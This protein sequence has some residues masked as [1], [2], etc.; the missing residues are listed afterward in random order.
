MRFLLQSIVLTPLLLCSVLFAAPDTTKY[1]HAKILGKLL[2]TDL[3]LSCDE[4]PVSQVLHQFQDDLNIDMFVFWKS[5]D[6]DGIDKSTPI[7]LKLTN[8][9]AIVVLERIIEKL[10]N[11]APTAWQ[12]RDSMLEIGFKER[13]TEGSA[14]E[15]RTYDV[16]NLMF[17]IRDFDNAPTMGTT[18]G[19]GVNF[20]DPTDDPNRLTKNEEAE[21][22]INTI[23]D[24]IESEQ[25]KVHGG[26]CTIRFYK[27]SLLVKA[28]DFVHRQLGGY[29]F[30]PL[31][32]KNMKTRTIKFSGG[33]ASVRLPRVPN[34]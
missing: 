10:N 31:K 33:A 21:Q 17:T 30:A 2:Y 9:P 34:I 3:S 5:K 6:K 26:N 16:M 11:T 24:F 27:G 20:G 25:W 14:M 23:T 12:L 8:Q 1:A 13:F 32:P 7:T 28:P 18:G 29:P 15:L 22:L 19:G 4:Q